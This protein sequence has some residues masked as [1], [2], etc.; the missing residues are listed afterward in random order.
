MKRRALWPALAGMTTWWLS[1]CATTDLQP[2]GPVWT[3]RFAL[4]VQSDPP[5][6][7]SA[8]FELEGEPAA[9]TLR[10]LSPLG[11]TL[12]TARWSEQ[13]ATLVRG[14]DTLHY[15]TLNALTEALTGTALPVVALFAWLRGKA[16]AADGWTVD[17]SAHRERRLVAQR[18]H[19]LPAATL[20]LVFEEAPAP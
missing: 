12:A 5:Q 4:R 6:S 11:Q 3:G 9:G 14:Q 10:I 18:H 19:P 20:R 8:G 16:D 7:A 17:L 2:V 1:G 13:G 15:T